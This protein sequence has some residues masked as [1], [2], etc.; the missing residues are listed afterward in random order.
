VPVI[1]GEDSEVEGSRRNSL[2]FASGFLDFAWNNSSNASQICQF[3]LT[4][5]TQT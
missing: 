2:W 1:L 3:F 5:N 4:F